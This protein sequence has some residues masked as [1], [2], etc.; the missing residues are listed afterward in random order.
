MYKLKRVQLLIY[1][2]AAKSIV[3]R[4]PTLS[5]PTFSSTFKQRLGH[6]FIKEVSIQKAMQRQ[7]RMSSKLLGLFCQLLNPERKIKVLASRYPLRDERSCKINTGWLGTLI[8][9]WQFMLKTV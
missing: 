1:I 4:K 6:I 8:I 7:H 9:H 3:T 2:A 5:P